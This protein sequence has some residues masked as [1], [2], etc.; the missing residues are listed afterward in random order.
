M[1]PRQTSTTFSD[2]L[3][4]GS[5]SSAVLLHATQTDFHDV[6][7]L[8]GRRKLL[9]CSSI[10]CHPDRLPRRSQTVWSTEAP[11]LQF[12]CMPPRQ[13][14][15][16]FSD[17]LV[18]GSSSSAVPLHATQT[19]FHD[20]LRLFGRR[21]LLFCSSIACH[22]DR[23]PRRSQTVWSTE[24]PLLQFYCMPPRQTST[25]FSDCFVD[26][27]SSSAVPLHATQTDFHDVL[28]LFGRRKLLFCSSIACHPDRLPR[29]SQTAW[30]TEAPLLQLHCMPPRQTPT[31]FSDYL[32]NECHP[33]R[34]PRR[35]RTAWATDTALL[36][37]Q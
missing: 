32:S 15:T 24:A 18:D 31:T 33:D 36:H 8:F 37:I 7:R 16:T 14:S 29:R 21:K 2:C 10:A 6:L 34:H 22:P 1:P 20:V 28:R 11:L 3:V 30:S 17:C 27:S 13:T 9:F 23:L 35:F 4:D 19:D 26:G 5:S 12:Y 25:T